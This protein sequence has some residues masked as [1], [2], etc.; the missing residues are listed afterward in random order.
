MKKHYITISLYLLSLVLTGTAIVYVK[1]S[2]IVVQLSEGLE[3]VKDP[4][5]V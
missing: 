5:G 2:P 4:A 1:Q 3:A